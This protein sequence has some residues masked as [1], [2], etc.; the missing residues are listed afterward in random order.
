MK[1]GVTLNVTTK[2]HAIT[3]MSCYSATG[4][5][6]DVSQF[7]LARAARAGEMVVI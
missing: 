5:S 7:D 2:L 1:N 3:E 6:F 4:K